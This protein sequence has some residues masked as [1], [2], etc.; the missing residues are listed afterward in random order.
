MNTP[1]KNIHAR[2]EEWCEDYGH[3]PLNSRNLAAE[4]RRKG[5][6]IERGTEN[7]MY[8]FDYGILADRDDFQKEWE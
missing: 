8:L 7:K 5:K 4:L 3:K 2:Y 1:L 6:I